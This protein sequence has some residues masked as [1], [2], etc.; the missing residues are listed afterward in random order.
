MPV[1]GLDHRD[2]A[3]VQ[4]NHEVTHTSLRVQALGLEIV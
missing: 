4:T 2:G 1:V 3:L